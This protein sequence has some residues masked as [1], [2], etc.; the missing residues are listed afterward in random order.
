MKYVEG[1]TSGENTAAK[2]DISTSDLIHFSG[3][4]V[5][6]AV[7]VLSH[8]KDFDAN[9]SWIADRLNISVEAAKDAIEGLERLGILVK[10]DSGFKS[11]PNPVYL[12]SQQ[13]DRS[14]LFEI[15]NK[16]K[17]QI[18][19]KI[20]SRS[21][22]A[23]TIILSKKEYVAEFYKKFG[24]AIDELIMKSAKDS[25]CEHVYAMELSMARLTREKA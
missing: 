17:K 11:D 7:D 2:N 6:R 4:W 20:T 21:T 1:Y 10:T 14:D 19:S 16:I 25:S 9:P 24:E 12:G 13:L 15:H 23:S 3:N 18:E 5:W 22:Y 8:A